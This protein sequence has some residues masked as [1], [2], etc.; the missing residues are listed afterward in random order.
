[1]DAIQTGDQPAAEAQTD[2]HSTN[3][4]R[5]S[6]DSLST[7]ESGSATTVP[8]LSTTASPLSTSPGDAAADQ[9]SSV[10][11]Q[12]SKRHKESKHGH[13]GGA[14]PVKKQ[15]KR[16][17]LV[18]TEE[19][20]KIAEFYI[21]NDLRKIKPYFFKYQT[22]AKGRWLGRKIIDVF[23]TEFRDR[24]NVFYERAIRDGR[25]KVN[26]ET[27]SKD[28]IIKNSDIV[29]HDIH[30]H[31]PPVADLPVR[32]VKKDDG[33]II[34]DKPSSIPV[35]PSGRY[36]HN[37]VLHILMKE[38]G[39][40]DLF[41]VN[42]LDRLTSGLMI[43]ALS[44]ERAREFELMMQRCEIKKEYVCKVIGQFP[45][46]I[47][48]C[49]QP[50]HVASFKLT[51]NTV[52]P[53]GKACSTIFERL[54]Y[55]PESNTSIVH[56]RPVTGRT[57][58]IRV[59]LQWLG[60]PITNDPLYHDQE[61]WGGLNGRG[62]ITEEAEKDVVNKLIERGTMEDEFDHALAASN[63][64]LV[65]IESTPGHPQPEFCKICG[66]ASRADPEPEKRIMYLH[67][68]RYQAKEW[69]FETELPDW[70]KDSMAT[71]TEVATVSLAKEQ[72]TVDHTNNPDT[73]SS[74]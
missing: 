40:R 28:Y 35:H 48:E 41:P 67:A 46:G 64:D 22:F 72:G 52:H 74:T 27:V 2:L 6:Q 56:A 7:T 34:V 50:I 30:R 38:Q 55:D 16:L 24:D 53:D 21:E 66:L 65:Q 29:A 23:N 25:I 13:Y 9:A 37:T 8:P 63:V 42:R 68:W 3:G 14:Q 45:S 15:K 11:S 47:T 36:R 49:H 73:V 60:H 70:A 71:E 31:E 33:V 18:D 19:D 59:H 61:I 58:Q 32:I 12:G 43:M 51:L 62:G 26:G 5:E 20:L 39:Y 4:Q 10:P 44:V 17:D 1:M 54:R 69:S 57:H